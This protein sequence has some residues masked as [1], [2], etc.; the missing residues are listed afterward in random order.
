MTMIHKITSLSSVLYALLFM[1]CLQSCDDHE[2][3]D[4]SI[5]VGYV[6]CSDH[7]CLPPDDADAQKKTVVGVVFSPETEEHAAMAVML[8]GYEG[9]YCDSLMSNGTSTSVTSFDG[10]SN[11]VAMLSS[12]DGNG[13]IMCPIAR[14][15]LSSH[16]SGQSDYIPCVAE[17]QELSLSAPVINPIIERYGGDVI[18]TTGDSWYWTSTEVSSNSSMQ[19]WLCSAVN[20]GIIAT[21]KTERHQVRAVVRLIYPK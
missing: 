20:G 6:L 11:T 12:V 2:T 18:A 14:V 19:A 4:T 7:S 3:I 10:E 21:P 15:V 5:H 9:I 8:R 13:K 17:M 1:C 16:T